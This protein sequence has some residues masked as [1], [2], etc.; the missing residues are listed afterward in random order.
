VDSVAVLNSDELKSKVHYTATDSI[1]FE[2]ANEK[3]FLY[4]NAKVTY[5]DIE[6]TA[7]YMEVDWITKLLYAKAVPDSSGELA[8]YRFSNSRRRIYC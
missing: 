8:G 1:R 4:G 2:I 7:A 3:V 6:L 5:E